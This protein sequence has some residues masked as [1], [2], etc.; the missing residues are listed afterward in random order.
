[1]LAS[2]E[3]ESI[4][5][6]IRGLGV[7]ND[8]NMFGQF[9]LLILPL[10]FV[11]KGKN[12]PR[13]LF[14]IPVAVLLVI[15]VFLTASRGAQMGLGVLIGLFFV[16]RFKKTGKVAAAIIGP[17]SLV[18]INAA[19]SRK[20]SMGGGMDRL[21]IWSDVMDFFKHSP[22]WGIGVGGFLERDDWTAHNSYLL[23]AAEMGIV[24]FFL[25]MSVLVVT[26][27]QLN[28]VPKLVGESNPELARWAVAVKVSLGGY[29]F[30]SYFLS[31]TYA[32][33]LFLLLGMAGAIIAA[34]GGDEAIPLRGT[35]WQAKALGLCVGILT[36]IYVML[37][38][39]V[40]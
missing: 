37:R 11:G 1:V 12:G 14:A 29:L 2:G 33:T 18:G 28:R 21:A 20:V 9:L 27:I 40:V 31:C 4:E 6:R 36:L 34:A 24:G 17:L 30:T 10:L 15:G 7:L 35:N 39:R 26:L 5:V 38:L 3:A 13:Y 32:L 25:W 16:S 19:T 23:C 8:P 22:I